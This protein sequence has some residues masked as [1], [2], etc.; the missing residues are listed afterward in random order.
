MEDDSY[1]S[2][3]YITDADIHPHSP[4]SFPPRSYNNSPYSDHSD[5]PFDSDLYT[6][7][8]FPNDPIYNPADFDNPNSANSL[9]MFSDE[10]YQQNS[11]YHHPY[12]FDSYRS[13]S[14]SSDNNDDNRSGASSSSSNHNFNHL[15]AS[16]QL[17]FDSMSFHSPNW[18]TN[19]LP[20]P[21]SSPPRLVIDQPP[22]IIAPDGDDSNGPRLQLVPA[23]PVTGAGDPNDNNPTQGISYA[24]LDCLLFTFLTQVTDG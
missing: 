9:L 20:K 21:H 18:G 1:N 7:P 12:T 24:T 11:D 22:I 6:G 19:P 10:E 5:L 23:T 13:P 4:D 2:E 3:T 17:N 15:H 14:P 16:P 8:L